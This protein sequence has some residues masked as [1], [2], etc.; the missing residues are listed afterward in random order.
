MLPLLC[1]LLLLVLGTACAD[2]TTPPPQSSDMATRDV[3]TG[4]DTPWEILWGPDN[5]IWMTER[6]GTVSAVDPVSGSKTVLL[7]IAE[8]A[9]EGESGLMGMVLHPN[10]T[11]TP[12]V[13]LAYTYSSGS[14]LVVKI[15][16]YQYTGQALSDPRTLI[17]GIRGNV[18][19]DGCRLAFAP[20]NTL[21]ITTGDA[22]SSSLSQ[23][24]E[25]LNGKILRINPD[26]SI[27]SDNP[28]PNSAVWAIGSRNAQGLVFAPDGTLYISEHGPGNDDEINIVSK[29]AN[30]GWPAVE[31]LCNTPQ[32]QTFCT[33]NNVVEPIAH[34]S[35]TIAVCG[36]DY[37]N[38]DAISKWKN[39][40]LLVSLKGQKI[41][42]LQL[43]DDGT[44]SGRQDFFSGSFG[45]LRDLC[46][47]PDGRV[48]IATSNKDGRG[49]PGSKD[50]RIIEIS[51]GK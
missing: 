35:A 5:R 1:A 2:T 16:R 41:V 11:N 33:A 12:F 48:F 34:W 38:S 49:S 10:F 14:N 46:I 20:D 27:P 18:I 15:V 22:A 25:S 28:W 31:G 47:A 36:L 45:R 24:R 7:E 17:D 21:F 50:D 6:N 44:I 30:Y 19:H 23:Q 4:L 37:Y 29:G 26:G 43:N 40:L 51:G 9:Q 8:V 42:H 32:E 3:I 13:Y 39:S